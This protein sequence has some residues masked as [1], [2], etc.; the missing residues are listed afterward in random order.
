MAEE[1]ARRGGKRRKVQL[2]KVRKD[3]FTKEKRQIVLDHLAACSNLTRAAKAARISAETVNYHR[4]RDP[5]FARQVVE[6][7][8]A[9]YVALEA[10][11]M[12]HAARAGRYKPGATRVA[13]TIDPETALHLLRLRRQPIGRR[14]GKAGY[15]P[16]RVGES[17]L[18]RAILAKL[19]VLARRMKRDRDGG[20][21]TGR[22]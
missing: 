5:A 16:K 8:E 21:A 4:R 12:D 20:A 18:N 22:P 15:E 2:R 1:T 7:I 6:A 14:T 13:G 10:A 17:E 9:G 3:G 19:D 11:A